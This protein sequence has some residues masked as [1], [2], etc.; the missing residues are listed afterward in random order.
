MKKKMIIFL[1]A[2]IF[3][4]IG[5][6][7]CR[8]EIRSS[9]TCGAQGDNLRW[10][11]DEEGT[12]Y[13]SG[14]GMMNNYSDN[15]SPWYT[16]RTLIKRI[17]I[18]SGVTSIGDRTFP[19]CDGLKS[20][21]ISESV[22]KI[23]DY[24]FFGCH[25]LTS[26]IIPEGIT[27]IGACTFSDCG[28]NSVVLPNSLKEIGV[29]ALSDNK[30][31][32][33]QIPN[34]VV[35][36]GDGAF[37]NCDFET[38]TIPEKVTSIGVQTF[39]GC[40]N[41]SS[42]EVVPNN[43]SFSS[44]DGVL[45]NKDK[46]ELIR[47]PSGK[48]GDFVIPD[49]VSSISDYALRDC[50]MLT[51]LVIGKN[52]TSIKEYTFF[53]SRIPTLIIP[54]TVTSIEPYAFA[55]SGFT[56]VTISNSVTNIPLMLFDDCRDLESVIL[57]AG[58]T[59][60]EDFVFGGCYELREITFT[61]DAPLIH[62]YAF[63][64]Y[65]SE[66]D[67]VTV[68][69]PANNPTWT[70]EVRQSYGGNVVWEAYTPHV[71]DPISST[72]PCNT[73]IDMNFQPFQTTFYYP[74]EVEGSGKAYLRD[75]D[76]MELID[77]YSFT[78]KDVES[79]V[80]NIEFDL[81]KLSPSKKYYITL[82]PSTISLVID[83]NKN[84]KLTFPGIID[85]SWYFSTPID[86][87]NYH[88]LTS[89][90]DYSLYRIFWRPITARIIQSCDDG[91]KG[92]CYG[93]CYTVGAWAK[94]FSE[95]KKIVNGLNGNKRLFTADKDL[96]SGLSAFSLQEY[97]QLCHIY[98]FDSRKNKELHDHEDKYED[99]IQAIRRSL[100][101]DQK[102]VLNIFSYHLW[103]G[104]KS[105]E[106]PVGH[107]LY[108][109]D[110]S[111]A[112]SGTEVTVLDCDGYPDI[113]GSFV[114][115]LYFEKE[116]GNYV[117]IS[118][119]DTEYNYM[120]VSYENIDTVPEYMMHDYTQNN[121]EQLVLSSTQL[122]NSNL[123]P[124]YEVNYGENDPDDQFLYWTD[125]KSVNAYFDENCTIGITDGDYE[126]S[127]SSGNN[128]FI[129][130]DLENR[131]VK[132]TSTNDGQYSFKISQVNDHEMIED[133]IIE[134]NSDNE[135]Q[136]KEDNG[137]I[138]IDG[139][140][141]DVTEIDYVADDIQTTRDVEPGKDK[142][143]FK[144]N[145]NEIEEL[146][147]VSSGSCGENLTWQLMSDGALVIS[148]VGDMDCY[149]EE[150]SPWFSKIDD[151]SRVE[152]GSKVTSI[153][154]NAFYGC[155]KI[156]RVSIPIAVV[157]IRRDAFNDCFALSTVYYAGSEAQWQDIL[158]SSGNAPLENAVI[159]Y[160]MLSIQLSDES[161]NAN[162][163]LNSK[164]AKENDIVTLSVYPDEGYFLVKETF[165]ATYM[166]GDT[167]QV[168]IPIKSIS[169]EN[170][171]SFL[172]PSHDVVV[173]A[174]FEK[175]MDPTLELHVIDTNDTTD[176][177]TGWQDSA[178]YDIGDNVPIRLTA[179]L[180]NYVTGCE[181]YN[182]SIDCMMEEGLTFGGIE[183]ITVGGMPLSSN[184]YE[185][186]SSDDFMHS[187]KVSISW[188]SDNIVSGLDGAEVEV[189][190][191]AALNEGAAL[192]KMGNVVTVG[193]SYTKNPYDEGILDQDD[194]PYQTDRVIVFTYGMRLNKLSE[195]A[196]FKLEKIFP[197][198][199]RE[200][201]EEEE[202][203][204]DNTFEV[205]GIDEGEYIL[206]QTLVPH[207]YNAL[208]SVR[209]RIS[210]DHDAVWDDV[211]IERREVLKS[212]I[213]EVTEGDLVIQADGDLA[214]LEGNVFN[215]LK[216]Y[217]KLPEFVMA[218][219]ERA[220]EGNLSLSFVYVPDSCLSIGDFAFRDCE[221]LEQIRI[222]ENCT[223][224]DSAF[225]SCDAVDIFGTSGSE[226]ESYCERH[227]NCSFFEEISR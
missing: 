33:I 51:N 210:A 46:T 209:I 45:F 12:L 180:A 86:F 206:T 97:I 90:I 64:S 125:D 134:A 78:Q 199:S 224:S 114:R 48:T 17:T 226:A 144:I 167:E 154:D 65:S 133:I 204:N 76:T 9:G 153:G 74:I 168:I 184:G 100:D 58:V 24:A 217:V 79:N 13:I 122:T 102:I 220:F 212:F 2:L 68:F 107:V 161:L 207:G 34:N 192:G 1:A 80:L 190:F 140:G 211:A 104:K 66:S 84:M 71:N 59:T 158:I 60:I 7:I 39:N 155:S 25:G 26:I 186:S 82:E 52:I 146:E 53:D 163:A 179:K 132:T 193:L 119:F 178:D 32:N 165:M 203:P 175:Y 19:F 91:T 20:V 55:H 98:Q 214:N 93:W 57:G 149:E 109:I 22:E 99:I 135:I 21:T 201:M 223:I 81:T 94:N 18:E 120:C 126:V 115:S 30:I 198:G 150:E 156:S 75:F 202:V 36:I 164:G 169:D 121:A 54:D 69:Y 151:I 113:Y 83:Q 172:M 62:G 173:T 160:S 128:S 70:E 145:N 42:I 143:I 166:D 124:V 106:K 177:A 205:R 185:L 191:Y 16:D 112:D 208:E 87:P 61:G 27:V 77:E 96:K 129:E 23:G 111:D 44:Q 101:T 14:T 215:D 5:A 92:T 174:A 6:T 142:Y 171:F 176:E 117:G 108:P 38:I 43:N 73:Y 159:E 37:T 139:E 141:V 170:K 49:S 50:T 162:I 67:C 4:C 56:S 182:I 103:Q 8:A 89:K 222:P 225:D 123:I 137:Y 195:D 148:G 15:S 131:S 63:N 116:N 213:G 85:K 188:Y 10:V 221:N 29:S 219:E 41:L 136:V 118:Y 130:L 95:I 216:V 28:L 200:E 40:L 227:E 11:L 181:E 31:K 3:I 35:K 196:F 183:R 147:L 157:N 218:I 127:V 187:F 72:Y 110:I 194:I 197:D 105:V 189:I 152:I 138:S 47:C 88:N